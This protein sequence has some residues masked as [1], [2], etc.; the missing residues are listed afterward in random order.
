MLAGKQQEGGKLDNIKL[1][2][3]IE[4]A[5]PTIRCWGSGRDVCV[6]LASPKGKRLS[7]YYI[8]KTK[9]IKIARKG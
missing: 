9:E 1:R 7:T 2:G 6:F 4:S 3:N 5:D 8:L